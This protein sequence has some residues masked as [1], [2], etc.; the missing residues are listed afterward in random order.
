MGL[1]CSMPK[2][3][4]PRNPKNT[5]CKWVEDQKPWY[6]ED[7]LKFYEKEIGD[8]FPKDQEQA[9]KDLYGEPYPGDY[10]QKAKNNEVSFKTSYTSTS[11][12][13]SSYGT[14]WEGPSQP[15]LP[16]RFGENG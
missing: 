5:K 3:L 11:T 15:K 13:F 8:P 10:S 14:S 16:S 2:K 6:L 9:L 1:T 4:E 7:S 12:Q